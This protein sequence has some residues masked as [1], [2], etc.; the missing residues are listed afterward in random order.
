MGDSI[1]YGVP[2]PKVGAE[3]ARYLGTGCSDRW[4]P[5]SRDSVLE[6]LPPQTN[7]S[8]Y[9]TRQQRSNAISGV[10]IPKVPAQN[11]EKFWATHDFFG[12]PNLRWTNRRTRRCVGCS[13]TRSVRLD[14][15]CHK[16]VRPLHPVKHRIVGLDQASGGR[17]CG[18]RRGPPP[19]PN[20]RSLTLS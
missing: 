16:T 5:S 8:T 11:P 18:L 15:R 10:S 19:R 4:F 14:F 20:I 3:H 12:R 6:H 2:S 7:A 1:P 9:C 13:A 17:V